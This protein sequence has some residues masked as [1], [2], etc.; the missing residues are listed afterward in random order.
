MPRVPRVERADMTAQQREFYDRYATGVRAAPGSTFPLVDTDGQLMGPPAVWVL[1]QPLGLALERFGYAIR[2]ELNLSRRAQEIAIL[3]VAQHRQSEFERFAHAQAGLRAGLS[4]DDLAALAAGKP[5]VLVSE[6]ERSVYEATRRILDTGS[7][8][9]EAYLAAAGVLTAP[10]LFELVTLV[11]YY[12]MLATQLSVF[13]IQP[14]GPA[15]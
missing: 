5:P 12:L 11:G 8:D 6:E 15:G 4:E 14:P 2:Y 7:L 3:M 10:R 9:H 13:D 1:S